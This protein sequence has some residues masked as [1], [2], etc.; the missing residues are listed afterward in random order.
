MRLFIKSRAAALNMTLK[1]LIEEIERRGIKVNN[2]DFSNYIS[3]KKS[4]ETA[5]KVCNLADQIL[6]E[7]EGKSEKTLE[8]RR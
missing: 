1:E 4:G 7:R 2:G 3:G 6:L 8:Q 5:D